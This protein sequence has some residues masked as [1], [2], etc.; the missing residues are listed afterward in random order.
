MSAAKIIAMHHSPKLDDEIES[1][2]EAQKKMHEHYLV[3]KE[4]K[5]IFGTLAA[6]EISRKF[7]FGHADD[8]I[9]AMRAEIR[10]YDTK[11]IETVDRLLATMQIETDALKLSDVEQEL[12][13]YGVDV[14]GVTCASEACPDCNGEKWVWIGSEKVTCETCNGTGRTDPRS[15]QERAQA[16]EERDRQDE[17]GYAR[18]GF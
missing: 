3:I 15:E 16:M 13:R 4:Y 1:S 2:P 11:V 12:L 10:A 18:Q 5:R 17:I 8:V 14:R 9:N 6:I 7:G